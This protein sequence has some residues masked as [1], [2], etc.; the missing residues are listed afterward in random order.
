LATVTPYLSVNEAEELIE[1]TRQAFGAEE[2]LRTTGSAGGIH[3][4]VKIGG[5]IVMIGGGPK[6]TTPSMPTALHLYV[7]DADA[8]YRRALDAG[9]VSIQEPFDEPYLGDRLGA[10]RD[11]AGNQW[12]I[13]TNKATGGAPEGLPNVMTYLHPPGA[14]RMI[15]FLQ[16]AFGAEDVYRAQTPDGIVHH[17]KVRI[18]NS[19]VE[20]GDPHAEY[21]PMPTMFY[22]SVDDTDASY[23]RAVAGGAIPMSE[24]ADQAYGDRVGSV[25]D[26][27]GNIWYLASPVKAHPA[28]SSNATSEDE[29]MPQRR[30]TMANVPKLFRVMLEVADLERAVVF[31]SK[32]LNIQ[33]RILRGSRAYF[34]CGPV[35]LALLDPTAGGMK[36]KPNP[37]DLYFAVENLEEVYERARALKCLSKEEVHG[38]SAGEI[39]KR[40]WGERSFYAVDAWGNGLC[41][42]DEKTL[43]TG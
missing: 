11:L 36:P 12:Y 33:G 41:F 2:L 20:L 5:S 10:V 24:P 4:E 8:V 21:Q 9:A 3:S 1:F 42:V 27:F 23:A 38:E 39:V 28:E 43:Y 16:S 7:S 13:A 37:T 18:G 6:K 25:A 40:P 26:S 19:I 31:Y 17:A 22:L 30:E 35:I 29:K 32:L 34:D 15:D 14:A